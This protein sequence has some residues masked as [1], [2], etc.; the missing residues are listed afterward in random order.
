[1]AAILFRLQ[2]VKLIS[3]EISLIQNIYFIPEIVLKICTAHGS[4]RFSNWTIG[5]GQRVFAKICLRCVRMDILHYNSS[6]NRMPE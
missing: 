3:R 5:Y 4:E 1:M 6:Q 2:C